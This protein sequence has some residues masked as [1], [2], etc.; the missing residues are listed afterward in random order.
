M[1]TK[2]IAKKQTNKISEDFITCYKVIIENS[3]WVWFILKKANT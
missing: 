1:N 3:L 2:L